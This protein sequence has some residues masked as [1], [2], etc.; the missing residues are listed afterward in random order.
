MIS[1]NLEKTL[2]RALEIAKN[3]WHEYA[4]LEHLLLALSEDDDARAALEACNIDIL[5]LRTQVMDFLE[6]DMDDLIVDEV[7]EAKPTAGFQRVIHRAAVHVQSSGR[8][9]V[10]GVNVLVEIFAEQDS[11]AVYFLQDQGITRLDIVSFASHGLASKKVD[12]A[13]QQISAKQIQKRKEQELEDFSKDE[14]NEALTAY[15][16]NLNKRAKDGKMDVLIGREQ[17]VERTIQILCRRSKNN[18]LFVGEAGVGKTALAEGLAL[19]IVRGEVPDVL[20]KA[21]IFSLDMGLLLAGTR[22]RGDFEE[23]LKS[24]V[25]EIEKLPNAVLYIDEIH[26]IIGAGATSGGSMDASNLLK[27]ALA[28]GSFKCMGST[29]YKE[30]RNYFEKERGLMRRFQKVDIEEPSVEDTIKIL[31]GLKPYFEEHHGIR[32]TQDSLRAATELSVRFINDR[33]LP[34]KAIDIIDEA[35]AQK[36]IMPES[37]RTKTVTVKDIES[38]ISVIARVPSKSVSSDDARK[39]KGLESDIGEK[40]FGQDNA[41]EMVSNAIR[42]SRAGLREPEKPIG[43]YL[44]TGP[45][46]VGKTELAKQL[47]F[48][49]NMEFLRFDMS[50]YMEQ[51]SVSRL[52]GAPPGYVGFDQGGILTDKISQFPYCVLLLDEIEKAHPDIYNILLQVMDYGKLTDSNGKTVNFRNVVLIMTSNAGAAEM[53]KPTIGFGREERMD[54]DKEAVNRLFTPE[55]RNRLDAVIPFDYLSPE[56]ISNVVDKF[57]GQLEEQLADKRV[58]IKLDDS[59]RNWLAEKGYDKLNGARPLARIIQDKV[60]KPLAEEILYGKLAGGG[61][62]TVHLKD[63]EIDFEFIKSESKKQKKVKTKAE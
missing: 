15:C 38:V 51:H 58:R 21:V 2:H 49:M 33:K 59:A 47:A 1:Q 28:R 53:T 30:Y 48:V 7:E 57:I 20:K 9:E 13:I 29:T 16:V 50:E 6:N 25:Q 19:R 54:E 34:D 41:V 4:G 60:K 55:F 10:N 36:M 61:Q 12:N 18:P 27:P 11:H 32:Y 8:A 42:M 31:R 52:I 62:V 3:Y 37:K 23:R 17:E 35:G 39:L 63:G 46:G 14:A 43:N 22:Y 24:V 5:E 26:T 44:F 40:V 45:T 56:T